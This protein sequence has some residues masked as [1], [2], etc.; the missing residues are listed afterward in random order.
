MKTT[1]RRFKVKYVEY[2]T[3]EIDV[4]EGAS[5]QTQEDLVIEAEG[6]GKVIWNQREPLDIYPEEGWT[7]KEEEEGK[8]DTI[9]SAEIMVYKL[10]GFYVGTHKYDLNGSWCHITDDSQGLLAIKE[11]SLRSLREWFYALE[12]K[13][14]AYFGEVI[15]SK[16]DSYGEE[17]L[18]KEE[19][20]M[21]WLP[22]PRLLKFII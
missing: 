14:G 7:E 22:K 12:L 9:Y 8:L 18:D 10:G 15:F 13:E 6:N 4:P 16:N 21:E 20:Q 2:G 11:S 1:K 5:R 3:L 17:Y 19:I